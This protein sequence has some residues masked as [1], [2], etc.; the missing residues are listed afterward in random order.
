M[1]AIS[2]KK[3]HID[4]CGPFLFFY[5][6][7]LHADQW[8]F[9][10]GGFT[11]RINNL[12]AFLLIAL[13][14]TRYRLSL[15]VLSKKVVYPLLWITASL[16][17]SLILSPYKTRCAFYM[18]WYGLTLLC[19]L[20][21]PYLLMRAWEAQ[22][23]FSLYCLSFVCV[24]LYASF[25]MLISLFGLQDPFVTQHITEHIVRPNALAA[26]PSF[27]ALYMTPFVFMYNYHFIT[28]FD[29]PFFIFQKKTAW[30]ALWINALYLISTSGS[31]FFAYAIFCLIV[32]VCRPKK[33]WKFLS[34]VCGSALLLAWVFPFLGR[35]F[36][37]KFFFYGFRSHHSFYERW[38]GIVNGWK[39]FLRHPFFGVGL[40]GYPSYLMEAYL[41]GDRAFTFSNMHHSIE[42][43]HNPVKLFEAT[44][45]AT[46]LLASLGLFGACAFFSLLA[47]VFFQMKK[48]LPYDKELVL[49]LLISVIMTL[50][51]LQF[52]Q[53]LFRTYIW[54]HLA[55]VFAFLSHQPRR[56]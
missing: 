19:Y 44:N 56:I 52:N 33:I 1:L 41:K 34:G 55:L 48:I 51:I 31:V 36:F 35:H 22:K 28:A 38:I 27:Y 54:A 29:Q 47:L 53:G 17:L 45:V 14:L 43:V 4:L 13:L 11:I 49:S 2:Q 10:L 46:E 8:S 26:E 7:T 37:L 20:F 3:S 50:F 9:I 30:Q 40:G 21:L 15:I 32:L 12:I 6:V 18:W 5:L 23:V 16:V 39:I 25:Q 24:G 42:E